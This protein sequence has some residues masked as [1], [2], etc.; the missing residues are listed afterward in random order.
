MSGDAPAG[1]E[2]SG[3]RDPHRPSNAAPADRDVGAAYEVDE[4]GNL[5]LVSGSVALGQKAPCWLATTND[6][7]YAY[8]ANAGSGT[9]GS[10]SIARDGMLSLLNRTA[11][12][13]IDSPLDLGLS[14][15]SKFLYLRQGTGAV[16]GFSSG[17]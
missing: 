6:G 15:D 10:F 5:D 1:A 9:I 7:R 16:S 13:A 17:T 4:N 3:T 11:A 12:G 2:D 14:T 8:T